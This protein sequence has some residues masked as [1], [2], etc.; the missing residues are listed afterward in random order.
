MQTDVRGYNVEFV[1]TIIFSRMYKDCPC[2]T[3]FSPNELDGPLGLDSPDGVDRAVAQQYQTS[4]TAGTK[5]N[6][7]V[8][9]DVL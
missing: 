7:V 3:R 9:V 2:P 4:P 8:Q 5:E 6:A 1:T